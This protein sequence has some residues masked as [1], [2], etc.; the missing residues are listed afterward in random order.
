MLFSFSTFTL[1]NK[2]G[3]WIDLQAIGTCFGDHQLLL[4]RGWICLSQ[5]FSLDEALFGDLNFENQNHFSELKRVFT[6]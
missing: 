3:K 2:S 1:C 6:S 4:I 5:P